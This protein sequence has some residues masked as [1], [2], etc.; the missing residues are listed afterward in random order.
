MTAYRRIA[1]ADASVAFSCRDTGMCEFLGSEAL[2]YD[3]RGFAR[4]YV[5]PSSDDFPPPPALRGFYT[6]SMAAIHQSNFPNATSKNLPAQLPVALLG[7]VARDERAAR[8]T[9][10]EL[11]ADAI[12]RAASVAAEIGCIGVALHAKNAGLVEYYKKEFGFVPIGHTK[13]ATQLM[14]LLFASLAYSGPLPQTRERRR[15]RVP[16]ICR[17]RE[18]SRGSDADPPPV[19]HSPTGPP[20]Q[21]RVALRA[22]PQP[23]L[24]KPGSHL[25]SGGPQTRRRAGGLDSFET[26]LEFEPLGFIASIVLGRLDGSA[27]MVACAPRYEVTRATHARERGHERV[28]ELAV[29]KREDAAQ[30]PWVRA[31]RDAALGRRGFMRRRERETER[32]RER[33]ALAAALVFLA[34]LSSPWASAGARFDPAES[35]RMAVTDRSTTAGLQARVWTV[36]TDSLHLTSKRPDISENGWTE[37][38]LSGFTVESGLDAVSLNDAG[39]ARQ[40]VFF[41]ATLNPTNVIQMLNFDGDSPGGITNLPDI[42]DTFSNTDVA[43]VSWNDGSQRVAVAAIATN[44]KVCVW[45]G[46]GFSFTTSPWCSAASFASTSAPD[47]VGAVYSNTPVFFVRTAGSN[48]GRLRRTAVNTYATTD[49]SRPPG[50]SPV[51]SS[52]WVGLSIA[53]AGLEVGFTT[54]A[55]TLWTARVTPTGASATFT[56]MPALGATL[57][58]ASRTAITG[59]RYWSGAGGDRLVYFARDTTGALYRL[60][61]NAA[62]A[63]G[64]SWGAGVVPPDEEW[65][66]CGVAT[67]RSDL[68]NG[69]TPLVFGAVGRNAVTLVGFVLHEYDGVGF[70]DHVRFQAAPGIVEALGFGYADQSETTTGNFEATE[71]AV[72]VHSISALA[73]AIRRGDL[74]PWRVVL[75]DSTDGAFDWGNDY[76]VSPLAGGI[77]PSLTDP[78]V[79]VGTNGSF[80]HLALQL[81]LSNNGMLNNC[82]LTPATTRDLLYRRGGSA[83]AMANLTTVGTDLQVVSTDPALDHGGMIITADGTRHF[84]YVETGGVK[85]RSLS[86]TDVFSAETTVAGLSG[87]PGILLGASGSVFG[88]ASALDIQFPDVCPLPSGTCGVVGGGGGLNPPAV[89]P[90][91]FFGVSSPT[92]NS[93]THQTCQSGSIFFRCF[94]TQQAV[95]FAAHP[96]VSF[97]IYAVWP[98]NQGGTRSLQFARTT[99]LN[100]TTWSAPVTIATSTTHEFIDAEITVGADGTLVVTYSRIENFDA[101]PAGEP[102]IAYSVNE[103]VN[104]TVVN[105]VSFPLWDPHNLGF[106]CRREKYFLGEYRQ[107]SRVGN[108][109]FNTLPRTGVNSPARVVQTGLWSSRYS[110]F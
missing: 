63:W 44:G 25:Q 11:V 51:N 18:L 59:M 2:R 65:R 102:K 69:D 77:D 95:A 55:G 21:L 40:R 3:E 16:P 89:D 92:R 99:A 38:L 93:A 96:N 20:T 15:R 1:S 62:G 13:N 87:P 52:M 54:A 70:R 50:N 24:R 45:E 58:T 66:S 12:E 4:I 42:A 86:P 90:D 85:H 75:D 39:T 36:S 7:R 98:A 28:T 94:D 80:H 41:A 35:R 106:H 91:I 10:R 107:G 53:F 76:V 46:L 8:G 27:R 5:Q 100:L 32:E 14:V 60:F 88:W 49:L 83:L 56:S 74:A 30:A 48:L 31:T 104:W 71:S 67:V 105:S 6:L 97:R 84:I 103:G 79:A 81:E 57:D 26:R 22:G 68:V 72:G 82:F 43:A 37:H 73:T 17:S 47:I 33:R 9:G 29:D 78:Y 101:T 110:L 64:V 19:G 109:V 23:R 108:R 61:T 34:V